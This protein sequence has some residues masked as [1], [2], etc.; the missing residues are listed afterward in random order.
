MIPQIQPYF[1][2]A[3]WRELKKVLRSTY[4][5]EN[6]ATERFEELLRE[7]TGAK[8]AIT[9]NNATAG[10]Y[11]CLKALGIGND[12]DDEVIVPDLTFIATANAVIMAGAKVV[13]CDVNRNTANMEVANIEQLV[14]SKTKA[15]V[16]VHLYG[17]A[18]DIVDIKKFCDDKKLYCIEDA[19]QAMGVRVGERHVGT[20]GDLG[21]VSFYGN[22]SMTTGEGGVVLTND[23]LYADRVYRL[24]NHG[25]NVKGTFIHDSIG[26]NFSF[27]DLQAAVGIAQIQKY[28]KIVRRKKE[29]Y[30]RYCAGLGHR[31]APLLPFVGVTPNY[32]F[33]SFLIWGTWPE[34][35]NLKRYLEENGIQTRNFFYPLH[36]QPCY[37]FSPRVVKRESLYYVGSNELFD[38]GISLPSSYSLK[39][40]EVDKIAQT[41]VKYVND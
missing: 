21:V 14:N 37:L 30:K 6:K 24:K 10:L 26:Y 20:F 22:K 18:A 35:D 12:P 36:R 38:R 11:C 41:M 27:T 19:A 7:Y 2:R 34:R 33:S 29:I 23:D 8:H 17:Y 16:P 15:I 13:F 39:D 9:V 5:T 3:E 28:D 31:F 32:W 4:F 25:R 1:D 40:K